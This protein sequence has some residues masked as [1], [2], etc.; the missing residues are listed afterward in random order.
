MYTEPF[1]HAGLSHFTVVA[2]RDLPASLWLSTPNTDGYIGFLAA[3][4]GQFW[5]GLDPDTP[6]PVNSHAANL[7]ER[8]LHP[9]P[10]TLYYPH[11]ECPIILQQALQWLGWTGTPGPFGMGLH[12]EYGS[13]IAMRAVF[14]IDHWDG[15][16]MST[17]ATP[18][19]A[20]CAGCHAPCVS[21]C[22]AGALNLNT[23]PDMM[24]CAQ[25]RCQ[26]NSDCA[27]TCHARLACPVGRDYRYA[28]AQIK[29]HYQA[30][31]PGLRH[32]LQQEP[33][34]SNQKTD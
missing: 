34:L 17:A 21:S 32:W 16:T 33:S 28:E 15:D 2:C 20:V 14:W 10:F 18:L 24:A 8:I 5:Q 22:Q 7:V 12:P 25:Y 13:W 4:G 9:L 11:S 1:S 19:D 3:A 29:H 27:D 23:L 26:D 30:A 31:L 6:H